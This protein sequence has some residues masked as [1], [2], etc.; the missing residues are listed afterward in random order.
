[1]IRNE[2]VCGWQACTKTFD[3]KEELLPHLSNLHMSANHLKP[4]EVGIECKWKTCGD[5]H[6]SSVDDL[7][8]H[9]SVNHL[10]LSKEELQKP[11]VCLWF[12]CGSRFNNFESLTVIKMLTVGSRSTNSCGKWSLQLYL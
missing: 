8:S 2:I 3:K 11:N 9:I 5:Q 1:M 6:F 12:N 10:L 4:S 7:F